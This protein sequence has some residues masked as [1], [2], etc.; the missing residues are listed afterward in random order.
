MVFREVVG[1]AAVIVGAAVLAAVNHH[2]T[3]G[4]HTARQV[5]AV[6]AAGDRLTHDQIAAAWTQTKLGH[7]GPLQD[8]ERTFPLATRTVQEEGPA[9]VL[10]FVGH[11]ETCIDFISRPDGGIT[12]TRHC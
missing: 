12:R 6:Q 10:T 11:N 9:V 3:T 8:V 7:S 1:T 5:A 2:P 4:R